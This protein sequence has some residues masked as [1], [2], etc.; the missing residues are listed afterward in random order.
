[1]VVAEDVQL[2]VLRVTVPVGWPLWPVTLIFTSMGRLVTLVV[3][4]VT[5]TVDLIAPPVIAPDA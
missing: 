5:V 2:P 3:V 1:M 4:G